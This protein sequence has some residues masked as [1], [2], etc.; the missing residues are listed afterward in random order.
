LT[1]SWLLS[2]LSLPSSIQT[3]AIDREDLSSEK[4]T[5]LVSPAQPDDLAYIIYT[6]GSTG[7][8]RLRHLWNFDCWGNNSYA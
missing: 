7:F 3:V 8:F 5:L 4:N 6:S 2:G 1:Q